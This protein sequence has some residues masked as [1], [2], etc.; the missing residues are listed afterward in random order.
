MYPGQQPD[1]RYR[2][3]G[4]G[5]TQQ[6]PVVQAYGPPPTDL[7]PPPAGGNRPPQ[8]QGTQLIW[9]WRALGLL[10]VAVLSGLVWYYIQQDSPGSGSD[11]DTPVKE[12]TGK[13]Q[14]APHPDTATPVKDDDCAEHSHGKTKEFFAATACK[15][16]NRQLFTTT[17]DGTKVY[18]SV[19]VVR[20]NS[21]EDAQALK[22]LTDK[23]DTGNVNDLIFE[24]KV[25]VAEL[26]KGGL[27]G[28][29][30]RSTLREQDVVIVE[31][32]FA[33][34]AKGAAAK[35]TTLKG[36]SEDAFRL[37]DKVHP[38]QG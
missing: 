30:Y 19:S 20:M 32:D 27:G 1:Y 7:R 21:A 2:D 37:A 9:V 18:T 8:R 4:I 16:L 33:P 11:K 15:S 14:F 6:I 12:A 24:G 25:K 35:V 5:E 34:S 38:P 3:P 22:A 29:G 23:N 36:V 31:S 17:V 28:G 26:P 10:A 13:Y